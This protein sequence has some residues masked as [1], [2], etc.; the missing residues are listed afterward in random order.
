MFHFTLQSSLVFSQFRDLVAELRDFC[1]RRLGGGGAFVTQNKEAFSQFLDDFS[2]F[3]DS[4]E[5]E[6]PPVTPKSKDLNSSTRSSGLE[7]APT[8][9]PVFP[10]GE[11]FFLELTPVDD[12]LT[13]KR[14]LNSSGNVYRA[15]I[16]ER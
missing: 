15:I 8:D 1:R 9:P 13:E 2:G 11:E 16:R 5:Q 6:E 14:D 4:S 10:L 12:N 7:A 3:L